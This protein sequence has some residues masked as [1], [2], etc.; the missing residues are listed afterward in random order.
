MDFRSIAGRFFPFGARL[1]SRLLPERLWYPAVLRICRLQA[2]VLR[3]LL[4]HSPYHGDSRSQNVAGWLMNSWLFALVQLG[5]EFP[6]PITIVGK[7]AVLEAARNPHGVLFCSCHIPLANICARPLVD[8]NVPP[9]AVTAREAVTANSQFPLWGLAR[10]LPVLE[11]DAMLF[12]KMRTILQH[13][14]SVALLIDRHLDDPYSP[15]VFR[16]ARRLGARVVLMVASLQDDGRIEVEYFSPPD[17]FCTTD[18]GI[19]ANLQALDNRVQR[20]L[21]GLDLTNPGAGKLR[22][23]DAPLAKAVGKLAGFPAQAPL[24]TVTKTSKVIQD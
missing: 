12:V 13:G 20:I 23:K 17:P 19:F 2:P 6:I 3:L 10:G 9:S 16:L 4:R 22:P 24:S 5:R 8:L 15:N 14:G 7:D 21:Y 11:P 18:E 1:L